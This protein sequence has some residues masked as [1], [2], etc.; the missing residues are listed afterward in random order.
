MPSCIICG[1]RLIEPGIR[2]CACRGP[3]YN[4]SGVKLTLAGECRDIRIITNCGGIVI[5]L[6]F[7][8]SKGNWMWFF[9]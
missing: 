8:V 3:E 4:A 2:A 5:A 9:S 7:K 6:L 1:T